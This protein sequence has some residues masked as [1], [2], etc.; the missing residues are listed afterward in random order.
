MSCAAGMAATEVIVAERLWERAEVLGTRLRAG[1]E[2][3]IGR[4]VVAVRGIGL[5]AGLEFADAARAHRFVAEMIAR[6]VIVNW[7]L[8]ADCVV[9][10]APPL[11]I[12]NA[13]IDLAID[14]ITS[15]LEG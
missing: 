6:G 7:T 2:R 13:E 12:T 5:L 4:E 1:L 8:N 11:T 9:R 3:L 15:A 10:M 14:A